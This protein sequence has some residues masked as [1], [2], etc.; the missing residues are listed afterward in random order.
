M[1]EPLTL[2]KLKDLLKERIPNANTLDSYART[3]KQIHEHFKVND[4]RVLLST[5]EQEIINYIESNYTNN[6]TI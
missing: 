6:S 4:M 5:K 2:E 3:I 1:E